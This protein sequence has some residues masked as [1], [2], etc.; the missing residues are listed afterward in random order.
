MRC[1]GAPKHGTEARGQV[2]CDAWVKRGGVMHGDDARGQVLCFTSKPEKEGLSRENSLVS[3]DESVPSYHA[4]QM[5]FCFN[6]S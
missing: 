1:M 5:C 3:L 6:V 2:L 4:I